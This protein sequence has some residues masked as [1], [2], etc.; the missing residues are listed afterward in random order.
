MHLLQRLAFKY[1]RDELQD[2]A[3]ASSAVVSTS[4]CSCCRHTVQARSQ[5]IHHHSWLNLGD[6]CPPLFSRPPLQV[7]DRS[8]LRGY[9]SRLDESSLKDVAMRL[10]LLDTE[11]DQDIMDRTELIREVR[12]PHATS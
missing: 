2:L 5:T 3:F 10:K 1:Y 9:L 6:S 12:E 11:A 7:A 8:K 4:T